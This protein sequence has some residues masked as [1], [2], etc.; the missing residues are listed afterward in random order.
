[1]K[2]AL[3]T[4]S[5]NDIPLL[6]RK[7]YSIYVVPLTIVW[8]DKQY[9]DGVD[10]SPEEFYS[11]LSIHSTI[12]TTSQPAP[13]TFLTTYQQALADGAE[14]I[15]VITI[16]SAM[17]GTIESARTAAK[18]FSIPVHILD[19]KSN[20]MSLGW[21]VLAAARARE[22]SATAEQMLEAAD[23]V[24]QKLHYHI[25]LEGIDFL[26]KGGR[27]A[28]AA[29]FIGGLLHLKP[30]IRV[31]HFSGTVEAGDISRTRSQAI[32]RLYSSFFKVVDVARPLHIAILHNAAL[33]EAE[34]LAERVRQ[35]FHPQELIISIVSPVL[36]VHTGPGALAL[37]GYSE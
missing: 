1:M 5:T 15:V 20:S 23:A 32:D 12:P 37:C 3:I 16:S 26:L 9:L 33:Q 29:R 8:G 21:E 18:D 28:G 24:R 10:L 30:Q 14:E 19:S 36:G 2:I 17:S 7:K 35:E 13:K 4:D 11:R 6:L 25:L 34:A 27:I 31:N 22:N